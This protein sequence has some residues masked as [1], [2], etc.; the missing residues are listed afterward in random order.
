MSQKNVAN[1]EQ[2]ES[3]RQDAEI[4]LDE[5]ISDLYYL[6][7]TKQG[8]RIFWWIITGLCHYDEPDFSTN[9]S[10]TNFRLGERDVGRKIRSKCYEASPELY[11]QMEKENWEFLKEKNNVRRD[12]SRNRNNAGNDADESAAR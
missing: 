4:Q 2:V 5:R 11:L 9:G 7:N 12:K 3:A 6:M 1:P 10:M 8:R